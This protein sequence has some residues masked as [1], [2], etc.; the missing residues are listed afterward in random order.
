MICR[1]ENCTRRIED[2]VSGKL[3]CIEEIEL[4]VLDYY[5]NGTDYKQGKHY[6]NSFKKTFTAN[7]LTW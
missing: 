1:V 4:P 3:P 6:I 2:Y 5:G 7:R